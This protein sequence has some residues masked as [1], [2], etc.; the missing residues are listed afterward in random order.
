MGGCNAGLR[1]NR[2]LHTPAIWDQ[3][4]WCLYMH[5]YQSSAF[6][7]VKKSTFVMNI[8]NPQGYCQWFKSQ[9]KSNIIHSLCFS[10]QLFMSSFM[11]CILPG[12]IMKIESSFL[13]IC[14][15][16]LV[17][18]SLN[19]EIVQPSPCYFLVGVQITNCSNLASLDKNDMWGCGVQ[20]LWDFSVAKSFVVC[21]LGFNPLENKAYAVFHL[22]KRNHLNAKFIFIEFLVFSLPKYLCFLWLNEW[23]S[24]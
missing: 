21:V 10:S 3:F 8:F 12:M 7:F 2:L 15:R 24:F 11:L 16:Y 22:Q 14:C 20:R 6:T 4:P 17:M 18:V 9:A 1:Q 23:Y 19:W 13:I 5:M